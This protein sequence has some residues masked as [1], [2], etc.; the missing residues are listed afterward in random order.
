MQNPTVSAIGVPPTPTSPV[1]SYYRYPAPHD[2][3]WLYYDGGTWVGEPRT[4]PWLRRPV[5]WARGRAPVW[6]FVAAIGAIIV[7]MVLTY[8]PWR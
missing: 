3:L 5:A 8:A 6:S 2:D 7:G 1:R 4:L